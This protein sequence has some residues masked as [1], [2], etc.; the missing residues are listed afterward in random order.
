MKFKMGTDRG[1]A[2]LLALLAAVIAWHS[3]GFRVGFAADPLGPRA[4]PLLCAGLLG[5]GAS[6]LFARPGSDAAW[7]PAHGLVRAGLGMGVF[8][9]F[10]LTLEPLGFVVATV[11][12]V[13]GLALL[14]QGRF[15]WSLATGVVVTAALWLLF[16][17][18]LRLPLP[19]GILAGVVR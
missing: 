19:G 8:I 10:A 7:P 16:S 12:A 1:S 14:F 15:I 5:L 11:G 6:I 3:W 2:V 18:A 4:V 13:T 9:L 17:V